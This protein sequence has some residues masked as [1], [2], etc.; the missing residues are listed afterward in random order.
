MEKIVRNDLTQ[1]YS[2]GAIVIHWLTALLILILFP[3]GK[4][5]A[6]LEP[7]E[8]MNLI[9][10]HAFLGMLVLILTILRSWLFFK[11]ERPEDLKTGSKFNDKLAV[12][13]HNAF[14][15][16]LFAIAF[17]GMATMTLGGYVAALQ[18]TDFELLRERADIV[19]LPFHGVL[20][21]IMM[22]LLV[23]H[24]IG[25]VKHYFVTKENALRRIT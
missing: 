7:V 11:R 16:I 13:I 6:G 1:K 2:K 21:M 5:M 9:K 19:S 4:Y 20:A 10:I 23:M 15:F 24:V 14:Y 18:S 12:W 22:V 3:L 17:S 25:V 8:K